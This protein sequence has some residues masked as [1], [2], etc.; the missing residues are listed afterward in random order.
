[1]AQDIDFHFKT[2]GTQKTVSDTEKVDKGLDKV[3][4]TSD[5]ATKAMGSLWSTM[6]L[7]AAAALAIKEV[8]TATDDFNKALGNLET[9]GPGVTA[10]IDNIESGLLDIAGPLGSLDELATE[11]Y[12]AISGGIE[13][14]NVVKFMADTAAFA[15]GN[16]VQLGSAVDVTTTILNTYG[17]AAGTTSEIQD[18]LTI[19][20]RE[21]KV[22]GEELASSMGGIAATANEVGI[23]F[24]DLNA[25]FIASTA[26]GVKFSESVSAMK[27]IIANIA[28]PTKKAQEAAEGMAGGFSLA[29]LKSQG[30]SGFLQSMT[31]HVAGNTQKQKDL[32]GS[33]EA[34]NAIAV[35]TSEQGGKKFNDALVSLAGS[36]GA[37]NAAFEKQELTIE[38][39]KNEIEATFVKAFLPVLRNILK[40]VNDNKESVIGFFESLL[41]AFELIADVAVEAGKAVLYMVDMLKQGVPLIGAIAD[42][43][44]K[45]LT[46]GKGLKELR[47]QTEKFTEQMKSLKEHGEAAADKFSAFMKTL[48]NESFIKMHDAMKPIPDDLKDG[49]D[50]AEYFNDIMKGLVRG[51][52]GPELQKQYEKFKNELIAARPVIEKTNTIIGDQKDKAVG[53]RKEI[54]ALASTL[55]I[56]TEKGYVDLEKKTKDMIDIWENFGDKILSNNDLM[57][58]T[59]DEIQNIIDKYKIFGKDVPPVIREINDLLLDQKNKSTD[60]YNE[61]DTEGI[62]TM[63]EL[64]EEAEKNAQSFYYTSQSLDNVGNEA[65]DAAEDF[66]TLEDELENIRDGLDD[67]SKIID[68]IGLGGLADEI[69]SFFKGGADIAAGIAKF[70]TD[71][72]GG[73][74]S[75]I[76]GIGKLASVLGGTN[77]EAQGK[78]FN[79][80]LGGLIPPDMMDQFISLGKELGNFSDAW[81]QMIDE[82]I[83]VSTIE[84]G[85][86][87][88]EWIQELSRQIKGLA[89]GGGDID[90]M[91]DAFAALAAKG[92]ENLG[93]L[94]RDFQMLISAIQGTGQEME[95]LTEFLETQ[96]TA[97]L[98]GYIA[99]ME[100]GFTDVVIPQWEDAKNWQDKVADNSVLIAG[101]QGLI[102]QT[103]A[104]GNL[105]KVV[106]QDDLA[107]FMSQTSDAYDALVGQGFSAGESIELLVPQLQTLNQMAADYNLVLDAGTLALIEQAESAGYN[108]DVQE[109]AQSLMNKGLGEL[110]IAIQDLTRAISG[111]LNDSIVGI[112]KTTIDITDTINARWTDA[113]MNIVGQFDNAAESYEDFLDFVNSNQVSI[114]TIGG[115]GG[116]GG[117]PGFQRGADFIVPPGYPNDTFLMGTSSGERVTVEPH[118][119]MQPAQGGNITIN[120]YPTI[121]AAPGGES[122]RSLMEKFYHG[123]RY[124]EIGIQGKLKNKLG[125]ANG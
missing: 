3:S 32:F 84:T 22:R 35:V 120:I 113:G 124:D 109:D 27:A 60:L 36:A 118:P 83:E 115:D 66:K 117:I 49:G 67:L 104:W 95:A 116:G 44:N 107:L 85:A 65:I 62:P 24:D 77:W 25:Y 4:K 98:E 112:G 26:G 105:N 20:I 123:L 6:A 101:I 121:N 78:A 50:M 12:S 75:I 30:L 71:P 99:M 97:G 63:E 61:I 15:K 119:A 39:L 82:V 88:F 90:A 108:M 70:Q 10:Q 111:D 8:W 48:D 94:G 38:G 2:K 103:Q 42:G 41:G 21:G 29:S 81:R 89:S 91:G 43:W 125:I 11:A 13:P 55:G 102:D 68:T 74:A 114:P 37:A 58:K 28:S 76:A 56:I 40:W 34:F 18:K 47:G 86:D 23:S 54:E 93:Y 110:T 19:A 51:E 122:P 5:K 14:A 17:S 72:L 45:L 53:L 100:A 57:F 92:S 64:R 96:G 106:Y 31:E 16:M 59:E 52:Y 79:A 9:L 1:M 33:V 73:L 7:G 46:A 80:S 69:N 87:M